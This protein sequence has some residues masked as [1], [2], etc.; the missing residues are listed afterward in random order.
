MRDRR[1]LA[2]HVLRGDVKFVEKP[3]YIY[4]RSIERKGRRCL[5][6]DRYKLGEDDRLHDSFFPYLYRSQG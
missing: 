5:T 1:A 2:V 4:G 3:G 6:L